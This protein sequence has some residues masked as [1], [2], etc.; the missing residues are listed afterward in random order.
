M[1]RGGEPAAAG[2]EVV[3]AVW[4]AVAAGWAGGAGARVAAWVPESESPSVLRTRCIEVRYQ[5][6]SA[7]TI[8]ETQPGGAPI[9]A[10]NALIPGRNRCLPYLPT[11]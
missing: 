6:L 3:A 10:R 11:R 2:W 4:G 1:V 5:P 7:F 9:P 8:V